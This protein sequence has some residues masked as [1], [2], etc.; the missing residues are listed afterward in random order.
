MTPKQQR[1]IDSMPRSPGVYLFKSRGG[2]VLY[3]GKAIRI[4]DRV[5]QYFAGNDG[6]PMVPHLIEAVEE[7]DFVVTNTE[8]E[9]LLLEGRLIGEHTPKFNIRLLNQESFLHLGLD[10]SHPWPRLQT[11][12]NASTWEGAIFGPYTSASGARRTEAFLQRHFGLRTCTDLTLK[13]R[14]RPCLLY[15]MGRCSAPCTDEIES[16]DYAA[17]V[18]DAMRLLKGR[19]RSLIKTLTKRMHSEAQ[20]EKFEEAARLRDLVQAITQTVE[21]QRVVDPKGKDRDI[22]GVY[23]EGM[24]GSIALIQIREGAVQQP[25]ISP[26]SEAAETTPELLSS[27]INQTYSKSFP[28]PKELLLPLKTDDIDALQALLSKTAGRQVTLRVPKRGEGVKLVGLANQNA[29]AKFISRTDEASRR[30]ATLEALATLLDLPK[31]PRRIECFDNSNIQGSHPVAA[32]AVFIDGAPDRSEYRRYKVKSVVGADDYATMREILTRRIKR[33]DNEGT[34]PDLLVV[35]GGKGQVSA[36]LGV[37]TQLGH[38][39]LPL[40]GIAKPKTERARGDRR[41][42]DKLII[43]NKSE[44]LR[45]QTHD[46]SL[47]LLQHIRD[48]VHKHA[49]T[50]HRKVRRGST[51]KSQLN[52]IPGVGPTRRRALLKTLGSLKSV[53]QATPEQIAQTPGIGQELAQQIYRTFHKT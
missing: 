25:F 10:L 53:S 38:G 24:A 41:A 33:A 21:R 4:R 12:R 27:A 5:K 35:D 29:K 17:R 34:L 16:E 19:H 8:K 26:I 30:A 32:M 11:I 49:I 46:S 22:W 36:V 51:I 7:V 3:I 18:E 14:K 1:I 40:V 13:S 44:P 20:T 52:E 9:A 15:Q 37:L 45:P 31:P 28:P 47:R 2:A 42:V 43:P 39:N 6:R 48:E 23:R 50:Y